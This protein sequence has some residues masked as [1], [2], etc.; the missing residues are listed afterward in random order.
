MGV[1]PQRSLLLDGVTN[2]VFRC[3]D[4]LLVKIKDSS[5]LALDELMQATAAR[6]AQ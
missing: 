4:H 5:T 6:V 2:D 3:V 1:L